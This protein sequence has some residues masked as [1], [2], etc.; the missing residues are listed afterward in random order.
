MSQ[1]LDEGFFV[2]VGGLRQWVTIRTRERSNPALLILSGAG[3]PFSPMAPLLAPWEQRFTLVQW[4]QPQA[5]ATLATNGPDPQPLTYDRLARDGLAIVEAVCARLGVSKMVLF[6]M[7]GGTVV[8]LRM[9]KDRPDLFSAYVGNGQV[10]NWARQERQS[11]DMILDRARRAG[12]ATAVAEI[13]AIGPPPWSDI[14]G[15][16]V[17]SR[18]ANAM[19]AAELA[20]INPVAMAQV[21]S[22]PKDAPWVADAPP[23]S[24]PYA[25]G[26]AA[27]IV[28]KSQL[29]VFDA[30]DLGLDFD[31]PMFFFQGD[32]DAHTP[33]SEVAVYASR[34]KAPLVRY[35]AI[36]EGGHMS[37]FLI[38]EMLALLDEHVRPI[39]AS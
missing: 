19:T 26:L 2:T 3:V 21:R 27:F 7:S 37:I 5:G 11:Y 23:V 18:Y 9:L 6:A 16:L 12:D 17:K 36:K 20:A 15:D 24:D 25:A 32:Q 28:L 14:A 39:A 13:E 29:A 8:A 22:P 30:E 1:T 38:G 4:D 31:V 35:V 33:A 10:T 34:L